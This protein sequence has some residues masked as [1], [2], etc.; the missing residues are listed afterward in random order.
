[1]R[2]N[3]LN[4]KRDERMKELVQK[5]VNKYFS[6]QFPDTTGPVLKKFI[7]KTNARSN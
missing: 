1:M 2:Y 3:I 6:E 7:K 5:Q 4:E